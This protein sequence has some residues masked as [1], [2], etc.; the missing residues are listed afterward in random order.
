MAQPNDESSSDGTSVFVRVYVNKDFTCRSNF[1]AERDIWKLAELD[2]DTISVESL[3]EDI[4]AA[5]R[6]AKA[7]KRLWK[8]QDL[9]W[10]IFSYSLNAAEIEI[11]D[12]DD[13]QD[14]MAAF[15]TSDEDSS[16]SDIE[17]ENKYFKV[18]VV[19]FDSLVL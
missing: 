4:P 3:R 13:L 17:N 9:E 16:D 2:K 7:F 12:D 10:K 6:K 8:R 14:E 18:R 11:D 15:L 5:F 1:D 19:F